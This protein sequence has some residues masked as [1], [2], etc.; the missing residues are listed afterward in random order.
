MAISKPIA[1]PKMYI[2]DII[3]ELLYI[4]IVAEKGRCYGVR[5]KFGYKKTLKKHI[6]ALNQLQK[7]LQSGDEKVSHTII[8]KFI[9]VCE[10]DYEI[11]KFYQFSNKQID[12]AIIGKNYQKINQLI[13]ELFLDLLTEINKLCINKR[14]VYDLL[15]TLH[16]L[17][18]VYLG[19]N[20]ETLCD[21]KQETISEQDAIKY[22]FSNMNPSMV[23]KY[24]NL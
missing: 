24:Q 2:Q 8:K 11:G 5:W 17:P 15:C 14:E 3:G 1:N 21:L 23:K 6:A 16:N 20:K 22:A 7:C 19:R 18:R 4:G 10:K 13:D 12:E 9:L